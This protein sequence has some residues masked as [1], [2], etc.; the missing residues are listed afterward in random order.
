MRPRNS[1]NSPCASIRVAGIS[2]T[3]ELSQPP[4]PANRDSST[5]ANTITDTCQIAPI[6]IISRNSVRYSIW[7]RKLSA[8]DAP[9]DPRAFNGLSLPGR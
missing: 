5:V 2:S 7:A 1:T 4:I 9:R 3:S 6:A 8:R